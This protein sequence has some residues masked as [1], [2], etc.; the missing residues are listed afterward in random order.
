[1]QSFSENSGA[2]SEATLSQYAALRRVS[3]AAVSKAAK[4]GRLK[5]SVTRAPNGRIEKINIA[6]ANE[7]WEANTNESKVRY[8]DRQPIE[9]PPAPPPGQE[10]LELPLPD[11]PTKNDIRWRN[12]HYK[13]LLAK[14]E[15]EQKSGKLVD[16][17]EVKNEAFKLARGLRDSLM[18]I[19]DRL[20]TEL[21]AMTDPH[22]VH[23]RIAEEL[24][25]ALGML[26]NA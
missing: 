14:I 9:P 11:V 6:L 3:P 16:A 2:L 10:N 20:A 25:T 1:M 4:D 8:R 22:A 15:Y 19:P 17:D 13:G 7:E 26:A 5:K 21:A 24:R 23:Q 18:N 12:E